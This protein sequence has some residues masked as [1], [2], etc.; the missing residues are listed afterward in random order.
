MNGELGLTGAAEDI[1]RQLL[2]YGR[3]I[4]KAE[5]FARIDAVDGETIRAV[6]DRFIYDQVISAGEWS[7]DVSGFAF[8]FTLLCISW[9]TWQGARGGLC[10]GSAKDLIKQVHCSLRNGFRVQN[11]ATHTLD[12]AVL[13]L[14][15]FTTQL[16]QGDTRCECSAGLSR[17]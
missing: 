17:V 14:L 6:A 13:C 11:L 16:C 8:P 7:A 10:K 4:P 5:M 15:S 1:G 9:R 3:R 12:Q 2:A